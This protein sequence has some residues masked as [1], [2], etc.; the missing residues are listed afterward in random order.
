MSQ[1]CHSPKTFTATEALAAFRRVKLTSSSGV[2]VEYAD[3]SDSSGFIGVTN[4]NALITESVGIELKG[5]SET[6]KCVA[7][8]A[9]AVGATLYAADDGK[10]SDT[11]SGDAIGTALE[12]ATAA[13]DII[14]CIFD[15]GS[16]SAPG[17]A[18]IAVYSAT[19]G[20]VPFVIKAS[21]V[22]AGAEDETIIASMPRKAQVI[23]AWMISRDTNAANVT[24][25]NAT[26]A[27]T[28]AVAKGTA[29]DTIVSLETIIAEYDE[30]AAEAAVTATFSAEGAVDVF[31]LCVPIA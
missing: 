29:D 26:N 9:L 8:E 2:A 6:F 24:L 15:S 22:A 3:Q 17:G 4:N 11:A 20:G 19:D 25:K 14:E 12:A 7:S 21:L 10:V 18:A 13:G 23:D 16:S 31:L 5:A 1:K 30:I 27:F 28:G